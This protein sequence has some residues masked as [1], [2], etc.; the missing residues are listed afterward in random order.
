M[1][2][3]VDEGVS[4]EAE[5]DVTESVVVSLRMQEIS[6][7]VRLDSIE[8]REIHAQSSS[9]AELPVIKEF[10]MRPQM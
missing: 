10:R 2:V 8:L 6:R 5:F 7:K 3:R 1:L 9:W 4:N